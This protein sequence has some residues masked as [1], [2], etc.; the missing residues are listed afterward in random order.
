M[1]DSHGVPTSRLYHPRADPISTGSAPNGTSFKPE[2]SSEVKA[3]LRT[4][5]RTRTARRALGR[6][7]T[8]PLGRV[9]NY[10]AVTLIG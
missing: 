10:T 8:G 9:S 7:F 2:T 1:A 5:K 6:L 3:S 4:M